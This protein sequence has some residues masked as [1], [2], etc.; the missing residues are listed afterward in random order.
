MALPIA[1]AI[2]SVFPWSES[3]TIKVLT[4]YL[5]SAGRRRPDQAAWL[6]SQAQDSSPPSEFPLR[7]VIR[8]LTSSLL[9]AVL[10]TPGSGE[11][12]VE[13]RLPGCGSIASAPGIRTQH[14]CAPASV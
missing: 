10:P 12:V 1:L 4:A 5:R 9:M 6:P 7:I 13:S 8:A 2:L 3:W 14:H 11:I